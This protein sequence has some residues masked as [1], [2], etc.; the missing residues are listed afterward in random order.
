MSVSQVRP[1]NMPPY[2][3]T[4]VSIAK[5]KKRGLISDMIW[6][7]RCLIGG[8]FNYYVENIKTKAELKKLNNVIYR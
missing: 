2:P 4:L 1:P 6:M 3:D 7:E 5:E 8:D